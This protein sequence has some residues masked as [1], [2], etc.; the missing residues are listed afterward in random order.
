[1]E[2]DMEYVYTDGEYWVFMK[3]DGSYTDCRR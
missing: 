3:T 1:M 2:H